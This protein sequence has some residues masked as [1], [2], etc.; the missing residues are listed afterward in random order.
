M[1]FYDLYF[2]KQ[3]NRVFI[4]NLPSVFFLKNSCCYG[5]KS[6]PMQIG[7]SLVGLMIVMGL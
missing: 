6:P 3:K 2:T 5:M 1:W 7:K 4:T